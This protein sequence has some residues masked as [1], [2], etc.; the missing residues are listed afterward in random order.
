MMTDPDIAASGVISVVSNLVPKAMSDLVGL[1]N[2]KKVNEAKV[3][4]EAI[5]PL[6]GLVTVI[7]KEKTPYGEVVCRARNPLAIKTLMQ[8]LGIPAGPCRRPMGKMSRA[9]LEK[10]VE[11]ANTVQTNTPEMLAPLADCFSVDIDARLNDESLW[12]GLYY[13]TY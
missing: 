3:L 9:G 11:I 10:V 12:E 7:T 6:F 1:L 13:P 4:A 5:E 8:L 2:E